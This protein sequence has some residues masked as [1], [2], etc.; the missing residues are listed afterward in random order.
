GGPLCVAVA[1]TLSL[2]LG[3]SLA[4]RLRLLE[5]QPGFEEGELGVGTAA[6]FGDADQPVAAALECT[7]AQIVGLKGKERKQGDQDPAEHVMPRLVEPERPLQRTED[8]D[9]QDKLDPHAAIDE[10]ERRHE[11]GRPGKALF[12][13][14]KPLGA[15][16][17]V[18]RL[19]C[20]LIDGI[21]GHGLYTFHFRHAGPSEPEALDRRA[22]PGDDVI[23]S[24]S[25]GALELALGRGNPP[26]LAVVHRD[27]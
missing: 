24:T 17:D 16:R 9:E 25:D 1:L 5:R 13:E 8:D 19:A 23:V 6:P 14:L 26:A 7:A 27:R 3:A 15:E 20:G 12:H 11:E 22:E 21:D 18:A 10:P 2:P 4:P